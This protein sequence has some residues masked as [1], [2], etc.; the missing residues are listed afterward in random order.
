MTW[1]YANGNQWS[2]S[3]GAW[4]LVTTQ[5]FNIPNAPATGSAISYD[6][7]PRCGGYSASV[8]T[9]NLDPGN[10]WQ[11]FS[12]TW[13]VVDS[14]SPHDCVNGECV[15]QANY[16]T[17]GIYSSLEACMSGC[18][19]N[20]DCTGECIDSMELANLQQAVNTLQSRICT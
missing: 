15:P 16:G 4:H 19:R 20:S 12:V 17:A 9:F 14:E 6:Y 13:F 5:L 7:D 8:G 10:C 18:A 2:G 3:L 1:G 11:L